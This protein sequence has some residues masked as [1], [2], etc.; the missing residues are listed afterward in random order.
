MQRKSNLSRT[1]AKAGPGAQAWHVE[2]NSHANGGLHNAMHSVRDRVKKKL[3][4][5]TLGSVT[6]SFADA[7]RKEIDLRMKNEY[8]S[9]PVWIPDA[10]FA[11]C[12]DEFCHQVHLRNVSPYLC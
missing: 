10:E 5:G 2:P 7:T 4:V 1:A 12:Y 3:L 9:L 6:D 8:E 11:K